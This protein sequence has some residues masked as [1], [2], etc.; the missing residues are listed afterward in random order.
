[1]EKLFLNKTGR[2]SPAK[3]ILLQ[4]QN[5]VIPG[6]KKHFFQQRR[7]PKTGNVSWRI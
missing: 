4:N 1:M 6:L 3:V 2:F 5:E 7:I